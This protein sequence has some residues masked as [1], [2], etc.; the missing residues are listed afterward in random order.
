MLILDRVAMEEV[1]AE[2][3]KLGQEGSEQD[4]GNNNDGANHNCTCK[5]HPIPGPSLFIQIGQPVVVRCI[6]YPSLA[7]KSL[8][9]EG[10]LAR[11]ASYRESRFSGPIRSKWL[12]FRS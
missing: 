8:E 11:K 1:P 10:G 2:R 7:A 3:Y 6:H 4:P 9:T 12:Y 5:A